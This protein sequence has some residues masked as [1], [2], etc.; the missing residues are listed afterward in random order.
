MT[1]AATVV[2][3]AS[4]PRYR[5]LLRLLDDARARRAAGRTV[6]EGE[7]LVSAWLARGGAI[8]E[9]AVAE[10][11]A[12]QV[13]ARVAR[14]REA[15]RHVPPVVLADRLFLRASDLKSPSPVL[16][17]I[18]P[19]TPPL[20]ATLDGDLVILDRVQDPTNVGALVRTAAAAGIPRVV[21]TTGTAAC[22]SPKCLRA[23]MG[24]QFAVAVHEGIDWAVLADRL[25][26]PVAATV[27]RGGTPLT[28]ADLRPSLAWWFGNEGEGIAPEDARRAALAVTIDQDPAVE[29]L[30]VTAAAAVC[31][32]EQ[33]RQR[34]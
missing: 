32:F 22:W 15:A 24:G 17:V 9:W 33:R 26:V 1:D 25:R 10:S 8:V 14:W 34:R 13:Q 29:S 11:S 21:T 28:E 2:R 18:E 16:A 4:N 5:G 27:V 6:L 7:H 12:A 19:P 3:S 31:L 30:N 20:P 23:G